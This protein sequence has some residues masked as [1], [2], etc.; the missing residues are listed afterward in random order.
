MFF[1]KVVRKKNPDPWSNTPNYL[2]PLKD[3]SSTSFC[4]AAGL[5]DKVA[6]I[7]KHPSSLGG[8]HVIELIFDGQTLLLALFRWGFRGAHN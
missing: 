1:Y 7:P 5:G 4:L 3:V 2:S 8:G 6:T